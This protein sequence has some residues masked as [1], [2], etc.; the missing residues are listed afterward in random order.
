MRWFLA[1]AFLLLL[2][3]AIPAR[4][5]SPREPIRVPQMV[6]DGRAV[7][8]HVVVVTER[9]RPRLDAELRVDRKVLDAL[10]KAVQSDAF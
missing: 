3:F 9:A 7:R 4:A 10:Q 8:P 5:D 2:A 1:G 6:I